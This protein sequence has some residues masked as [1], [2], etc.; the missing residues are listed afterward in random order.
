MDVTL[1]EFVPC[2]CII[3]SDEIRHT[4][5]TGT[6]KFTKGTMFEEISEIG[7]KIVCLLTNL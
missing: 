1:G 4:S 7:I 5:S 2:I 3:V 6:K